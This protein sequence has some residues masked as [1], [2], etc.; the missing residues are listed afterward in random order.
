[1]ELLVAHSG[2]LSA[3]LNAGLVGILDACRDEGEEIKIWG[4]RRGAEGLLGADWADLSSIPA[5]KLEGVM[6][7]PGSVIG[8][9]RRAVSGDEARGI[10]DALGK[11]GVDALVY[12]GGNGSMAAAALLARAAAESK[13]W[14]KVIG[15]PN[16]L[17]NDVTC[18]DHAPGFASA[19]RFYALAVRDIAEDN[20]ALPSPI[21][22]IEAAGRNTGWVAAA[23]ALG[24]S[25][26]DDGPHL[27]YLPEQ[28]PDE[29]RII[30]DARAAVERWGRA[31]IVVCEGLRDG[32]GR[33][34]GA[35]ELEQDA[36]RAL[37]HCIQAAT[38]IR[39]RAERPGLL[40]RSCSWTISE[41]DVEESYRCGRAAAETAL[42]GASGVM[43]AL[44][45]RVGL[46]Y[47]SFPNAVP[48]SED[49]GRE[50]KMPAQ[51]VGAPGEG[52]TADY[53]EWLRPL[54]G[55]IPA[56]ERIL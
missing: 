36:G 4:A 33:P 53:L 55:E 54:V 16:A 18:T 15:L 29:D 17:A 56:V 22:V 44:R 24:R 3:T 49:P 43:I 28:T 48:F 31:V 9:S 30:Q 42:G 5:A 45:R 8:S 10:V 41:V 51:F 21:T 7:A 37:A 46:A 47:Q 13:S 39:A 20:R 19:A 11:R 52:G 12:T 2:G 35:A 34:F 40:G 14:I 26:E 25:S 27:I 32:S 6:R 38:G 1:M 50:R 23:A